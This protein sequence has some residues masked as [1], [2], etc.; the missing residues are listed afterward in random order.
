MLTIENGC[1]RAGIGH[2]ATG[3]LTLLAGGED[4]VGRRVQQKTEQ[5]A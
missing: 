3:R 4:L 2:F 1:V 5:H